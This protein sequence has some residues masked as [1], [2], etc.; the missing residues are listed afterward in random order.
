MCSS[1]LSIAK[2]AVIERAWVMAA[3]IT[4]PAIPQPLVSPVHPLK[5]QFAPAVAVK[6]VLPSLAYQP[7]AAVTV[8]LPLVAA[9]SRYSVCQV[10]VSVASLVKV[11]VTLVAETG[12]NALLST[13]PATHTYCVP[14]P[15]ETGELVTNCE[16]AVF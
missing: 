9:V 3:V 1:D 14:T 15:P 11:K 4:L 8:P 2:F 7:S 12:V 10:Q 16:S 5:C 13:E 6:V